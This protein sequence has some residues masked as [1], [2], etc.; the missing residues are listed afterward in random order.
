MTEHPW[1]TIIGH[2]PAKS[3]SYEIIWIS[4][5]PTLGKK[6][7][8]SG[9]EN[10]FYVQVGAYRNMMISGIFELYAR[11]YFPTMSNDLD[12]SMKTLLDCLQ[13]TKT[14]KNDNKCIKIVA[15]KF[16]D[17]N[18]PRVEFRLVEI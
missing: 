15:E 1:Q 7:S 4:G 10:S 5:H 16:I 14:I 3:N 2:I 11:V 8:V 17:K 12:N 13:Y 9:Y 18:N 6:K